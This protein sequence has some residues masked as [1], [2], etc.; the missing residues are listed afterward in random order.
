MSREPVVLLEDAADGPA[1]TTATLLASLVVRVR[2]L[3]LLSGSQAVGSLVAGTAALGRE[4]SAGT[5]GA[6]IRSALERTRAGVNAEAL[7]SALRL[8]D[9]ASI[10]PPT[11]VLEDLRNDVALLVAPDLEQAVVGLDEGS[12]GAGIGLVR[13]PQPVDV[14]DFLVGLWALSRFLTD[15]VELLAEPAAEALAAEPSEAVR[16]DDGPLLR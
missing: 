7:W 9:L 2:T 4:V 11:P 5:E 15:A 3:T 8:G 6:R 14:L 1:R 13:E 12:L 10:L 16:P